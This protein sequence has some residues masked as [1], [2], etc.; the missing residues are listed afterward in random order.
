MAKKSEY[1][2]LPCLMNMS[3]ENYSLFSMNWSY[4]LNKGLNLFIGAN[5]LGKTTT[6]NLIIY[7]IVGFESDI[8]ADYFRNRGQFNEN[9]ENDKKGEATVTLEFY[10]GEHYFK[11]KRSIEND[12]IKSLEIDEEIYDE[13]DNIDNLDDIY[14]YKLIEYT[15]IND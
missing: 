7:G 10:I 13:G 1:I 14:E 9:P 4:K 12:C 15:G 3:I 11:I 6:T 5:G 2:K 8:S